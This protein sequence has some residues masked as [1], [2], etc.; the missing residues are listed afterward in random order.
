[1]ISKTSK[2]VINL[3]LCSSEES[4]F[5]NLKTRNQFD[6]Y[7]PGSHLANCTIEKVSKN[8]LQLSLPNDLF[9]YV[10][11]NHIPI[12]KRSKKLSEIFTSG[13]KLTGTIIFINPYSKIIY[14][15]VLPHLIDSRKHSKISGMFAS[16]N[17]DCLRLG[18]IVE[19]AQ[20]SMHTFKGIY[21][22]FD[23]EYA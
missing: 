3:K 15:S 4:I 22:R 21:V 9:A 13:E 19:N 20:V 11:S 10:H 5:Y 23:G 16:H 8:G 14:L 18:Q 7:L 17:E 2:R 1:M 6:T 12:N